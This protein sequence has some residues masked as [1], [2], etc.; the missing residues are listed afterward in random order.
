MGFVFDTHGGGDD[1]NVKQI[2]V[3]AEDTNNIDGASVSFNY[4]CNMTDASGNDFNRDT[5]MARFL[6]T[7]VL[8]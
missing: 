7:A 6:V 3:Y 1:H 2:E 8:F 4:V 5:S